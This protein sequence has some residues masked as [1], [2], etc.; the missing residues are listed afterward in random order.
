MQWI[1]FVLLLGVNVTLW[2]LVSMLRLSTSGLVRRPPARR[3]RRRRLSPDDVAVLIPAHNEELVIA[4][5]ITSVLKVAPAGNVHVIADGCHD[6]TAVVAH[7]YGVNVLQLYPARGKAGGIETAVHELRLA[8]RF[9][10][11]L[12]VDADTELDDQYLEHALPLLDNRKVVAI[13]GYARTNWR[14]EELSLVGRFLIAYRTR[15]YAVMQWIK[16]GQTWRWTN[17]TAIVPGFASMY[18]TRALPRMDLNPA[19]LVIEDF[20]MT[21]E[22]HRKGLGRIAFHPSVFATTQD[23]DNFPD[24]YRQVKRWFLGFW[25]TVRRHGFWPSWFSFFLALFVLEVV[26][27]SV[28]IIAVALTPLLLALPALTGD[29]VLEVTWVASIHAT[30]DSLITVPN[31]ALFLFLPD[32]LLTCVA[33]VAMRRPSLLL[34]GVG[35]L[36]LRLVDATATLWTL[37]QAWWARS[38]GRWQSPARRPPPRLPPGPAG[39][40]GAGRPPPAGEPTPGEVSGRGDQR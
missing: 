3:T 14:P 18:R 10:A 23:P 7:S 26:S 24:Y 34:Y 37:P 9:K 19:G 1:V 8:D 4:S 27:A 21:F 13:A 30:A 12:I 22:V 5:T 31:L 32:Y 29:A 39:A 2:T 17:V 11:V 40:P 35:F 28:V 16:Y 25:Q 38:T 6:D 33:A 20:N 15:L 36:I